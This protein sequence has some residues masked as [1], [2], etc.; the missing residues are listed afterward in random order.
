MALSMAPGEVETRFGEAFSI[1]KIAGVLDWHSFPPG[2]AAYL[3]TR[4]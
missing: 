3:M 4:R 2:H 1:E